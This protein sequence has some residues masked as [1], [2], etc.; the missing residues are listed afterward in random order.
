MEIQT[1]KP[2]LTSQEWAT[3]VRPETDREWELEYNFRRLENQRVNDIDERGLRYR[4]AMDTA[5]QTAR[6]IAVRSWVLLGTVGAI[7]LMPI[8]AMFIGIEAQTF[9][10]FI[11]PITG[12]G[13][14]VLGYWFSQQQTSGGIS[15][16]VIPRS[17]SATQEA[18]SFPKPSP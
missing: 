18:V 10:Q 3:G 11:A 9:S 1:R 2:P 6:G 17:Q 8:V 5:M 15:D 13:G 12:I 7:I 16:T 14:T 4:V